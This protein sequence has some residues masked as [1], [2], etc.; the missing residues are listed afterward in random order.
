MKI[1]NRRIC[2]AAVLALAAMAFFAPRPAAA[3]ADS[4]EPP[5]FLHGV[6]AGDGYNDVLAQQGW[7]E[8][9]NGVAIF[10]SL[11]FDRISTLGETGTYRIRFLDGRAF[12]AEL[13]IRDADAMERMIARLPDWRKHQTLVYIHT[14]NAEIDIIK[15]VHELGKATALERFS[16]YVTGDG[17]RDVVRIEIV[18]LQPPAE[19]QFPDANTYLDSLPPGGV[20][21]GLWRLGMDISRGFNGASMLS[22]RLP[23][24][25]RQL[26]FPQYCDEGCARWSVPEQNAG[27]N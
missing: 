14:K 23:K 10:R 25:D 3:E 27:R 17:R 7:Y 18:P 9:S 13:V 15:A 22:L 8:C 16:R 20:I 21:L 6:R 1:Q 19:Q 5:E 4:Y 2:R 11:C 12:S 24:A 26:L